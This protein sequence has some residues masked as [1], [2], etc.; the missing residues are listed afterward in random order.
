MFWLYIASGLCAATLLLHLAGGG[1]SIA[2]PVLDSNLDP[3]PKFASYYC[4]H[5][6]SMIIAF[7]GI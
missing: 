6:V 5:I 7:M 4:W 1:K 3:E 2:R